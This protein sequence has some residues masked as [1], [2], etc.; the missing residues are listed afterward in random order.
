MDRRQKKRLLIFLLVPILAVILFITDDIVIRIVTI[1]LMVIYVAFI[2]FLRDSIRFNNGYSELPEDDYKDDLYNATPGAQT[3][4][5]DSFKIISKNSDV[6]IITAENYVPESGVAKSIVKPPDLKEKFEEI[7]YEGHWG[8]KISR[9]TT[10]I[11]KKDTQILIE[12]IFKKLSFLDRENLLLNLDK[13]IDE[14]G[15]LYLRLDKQRICKNKISLSDTEGIKIKFKVNKNQIIQ[16]TK[17]GKV[18]DEI[19]FSYRRLIQSLEK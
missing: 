2:I 8:N 5:G 4:F 3:D 11:N 17:S 13:H 9:L 10:V 19:Y 16:Y 12:K 15:N 1:A 18:E 7:E 14:K 6:D